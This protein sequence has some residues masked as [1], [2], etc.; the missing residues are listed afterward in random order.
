MEIILSTR[1]PSK[2]E[3]I[4]AVFA[5]STFVT[6]T[7]EDA[8]IEGEVIE[9]GLTLQENSLKKARY[10]HEH[11]P[12][13]MWTMA[14]DTGIFI[15]A[16]M[17]EPGIQAAYWGGAT[18][19]AEERMRFVIKQMEGIEDRSATFRTCVALVSPDGSEHFFIGEAHG[20]ILETP[21]VDPQLK[22]PY[23][24]IFVP[25]GQVKSW[26]EMDVDYENKISHR[27]KAFAQ[28]RTFL[29]TLPR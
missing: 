14:D 18:L 22:M 4:K 19:S 5:G 9:D 15:D 10:A 7:L 8:H 23:S 28:V 16:L 20:K 1:N 11:A 29:E 25:D 2:A 6:L 27:G 12:A 17:G 26:A 13:G 3:Q 21:R 24:P